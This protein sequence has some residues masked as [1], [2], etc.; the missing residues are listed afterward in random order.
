V[1]LV[2]PLAGL[3]GSRTLHTLGLR[4]G[5]FGFKPFGLRSGLWH[6]ERQKGAE[7]WMETDND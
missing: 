5:V 2:Q 4:P 6:C 1:D 3:R 7:P